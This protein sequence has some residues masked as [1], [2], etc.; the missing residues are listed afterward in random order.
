MMGKIVGAGGIF[1]TGRR[2]CP[3]DASAAVAGLDPAIHR[4][5]NTAKRMVTRAKP[6][7]DAQRDCNTLQYGGDI[8]RGGRK[9]HETLHAPNIDD[10]QARAAVHRRAPDSSGRR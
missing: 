5:Q 8:S 4:K 6:A 2:F 3:P 7:Y 10:E 1:I 9:T